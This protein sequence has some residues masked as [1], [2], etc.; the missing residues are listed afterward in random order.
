LRVF[1]AKADKVSVLPI[2]FQ[3]RIQADREYLQ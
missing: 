2:H 1:I 3:D